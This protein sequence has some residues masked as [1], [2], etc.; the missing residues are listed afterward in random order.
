MSTYK[1]S[2]DSTKSVCRIK[3]ILHL[4]HYQHAYCCKTY[5]RRQLEINTLAGYFER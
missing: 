2:F 1:Y 3:G 4:T 5:E